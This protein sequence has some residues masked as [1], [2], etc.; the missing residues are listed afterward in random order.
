VKS[1]APP[2]DLL[3]K[4]NIGTFIDDR[5]RIKKTAARVGL[6]IPEFYTPPDANKIAEKYQRVR[7]V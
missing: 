6:S 2:Q 4:Y 3:I 7:G 5:E 1:D